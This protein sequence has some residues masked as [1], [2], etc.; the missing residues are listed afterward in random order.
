MTDAIYTNTTKIQDYKICSDFPSVDLKKVGSDTYK[1]TDG[2]SEVTVEVIDSTADHVKLLKSIFDFDAIKALL[3]RR[4]FSMVY[5]S[6]HG[7]NGPYAKAV[8]IDELSQPTS[9][10]VNADPKDDF[11]GGHADPNLTYAKE[12]VAAMDLDRKGNTLIYDL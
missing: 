7:V 12:I 1:S 10:C 4:D 9:T 6:M 11:G 3:N 2:K 8:F 5:D